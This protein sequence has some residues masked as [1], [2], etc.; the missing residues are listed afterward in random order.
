L[1][2]DCGEGSYGQLV[3]CYGEMIS[4]VLRDLKAIL[5]THRHADHH[6]G[7]V[8]IL[9]ER[10]KL[11]DEP[12]IVVAPARYRGYLLCC[13]ATMGPLKFEFQTP[14]LINI[15]IINATAVP[16]EHKIEAYGFVLTHPAG[17]KVVY[18]GDTRPCT[19]LIEKGFNATILIHEATFDDTLPEMAVNKY[20]STL[21]E[22]L[23]VA[24]AMEVWKV[25]LTHFSQRYSKIPE[26]TKVDAVYAFDLMKFKL[27]DCTELVRIMPA[28]VQE[29]KSDSED[30]EEAKA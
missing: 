15:P 8:K 9:Y 23:Q 16:V 29:W 13:E 27:S 7:I 5:I 25:I 6:L 17:W 10:A 26:N 3:R 24:S 14:D 11:T 12:V 30:E 28:L 2:F 1:L 18:S 19:K 21:S 22:A 4:D 20:H